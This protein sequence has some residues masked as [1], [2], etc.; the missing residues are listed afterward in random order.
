MALSLTVSARIYD[1]IC[2]DLQT[3]QVFRFIISSGG[4]TLPQCQI[5][6]ARR[7]GEWLNGGQLRE[8]QDKAKGVREVEVLHRRTIGLNCILLTYAV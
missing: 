1:E 8:M 2:C 5:L 7:R 4:P 3:E 6:S